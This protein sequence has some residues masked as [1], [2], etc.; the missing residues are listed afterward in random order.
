M[1]KPWHPRVIQG[2]RPK[3]GRA[4]RWGRH[5]WTM[6]RAR[7]PKQAALRRFAAQVAAM[8]IFGVAI[9]LAGVF[10]PRLLAN[11][12]PERAPPEIRIERVDPYAEARRS[13]A[14]LAAQE[15][16]PTGDLR[17]TAAAAGAGAA[18]RGQRLSPAFVRI[19]D[20]D[21][22]DYGGTRVRVA[23]IDAPETHPPR[24]AYEAELGERA[25]MRMHAL[26]VAGPFELRPIAGRDEDR[27]GR[28]L[29]VVMR[30]GRSLG[31]RLVAEG[32]A[33]TWTG[34]RQPWC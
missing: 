20:G 25:T 26:L 30:G 4:G 12:T 11:D 5:R 18:G 1:S 32:L 14:I 15:A 28:K 16:A 10:G 9:G 24:C 3:R 33:R 34:H 8:A 13:R 31:D 2:G 22:F 17:G 29:R 27:Y 23:D 6:R 7:Q 19:I 21:T